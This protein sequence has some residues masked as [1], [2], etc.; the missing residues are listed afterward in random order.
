M[1]VL[2]LIR[3][4][5]LPIYVSEMI[6]EDFL[7]NNIQSEQSLEQNKFIPYMV[8]FSFENQDEIPPP[9]RLTLVCKTQIKYQTLSRG[10]V[11]KMA[12][13]LLRKQ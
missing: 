5:S 3:F 13:Y 6:Q 2:R 7:L 10:S 4:D 11:T 12:M 1:K 8:K 9:R